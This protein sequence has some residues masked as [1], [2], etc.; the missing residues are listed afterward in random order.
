M[1]RYACRFD[2]PVVNQEKYAQ[3][4]TERIVCGVCFG[5]LTSVVRS[6]A[7]SVDGEGGIERRLRRRPECV[8]RLL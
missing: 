7:D 1:V 2:N 6:Y 3:Y 5:A 8:G 4:S